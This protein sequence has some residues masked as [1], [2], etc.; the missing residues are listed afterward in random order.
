MRV[1][2]REG[3]REERKEG[4]TCVVAV[5]EDEVCPLKDGLGTLLGK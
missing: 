3:G 5:V 4:R 2:G 1:Q